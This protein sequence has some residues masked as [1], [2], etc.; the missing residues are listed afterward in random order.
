M[1]TLA[2]AVGDDSDLTGLCMQMDFEEKRKK[3]TEKPWERRNGF[4]KA[5][6]M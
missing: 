1:H 4:R 6:R 3:A 2:M 5:L